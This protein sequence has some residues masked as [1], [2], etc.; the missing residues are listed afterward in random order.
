M[1]PSLSRSPRGG[2]RGEKK[3]RGV[4]IYSYKQGQANSQRESRHQLKL[5]PAA[6]KKKEKGKEEARP[7]REMDVREEKEIISSSKEGS[8]RSRFHF[9]ARLKKKKEGRAAVPLWSVWGDG[10]KHKEEEGT[11]KIGKFE[12]KRKEERRRIERPA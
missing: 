3:K 1:T 2:R 12:Y 10:R 11:Q 6:K 4:V 8:I 9:V 7:F 5:M